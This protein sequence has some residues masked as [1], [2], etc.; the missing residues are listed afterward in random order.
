M[1]ILEQMRT[2]ESMP[3]FDPSKWHMC[4]DHSWENCLQTSNCYAYAL[5]RPDYHWAIPGHGFAKARPR[6][7]FESYDTFFRDL[8]HADHRECLVQGACQD[9]LT[10]VSRPQQKAGYYSVAL[11]FSHRDDYGFHW[12]R[13]DGDGT[14]SHKDGWRTVSNRDTEGRVILDP[15]QDSQSAYSI[16][17]GFFLAPLDGIQLQHSFPPLK[18]GHQSVDLIPAEELV[19]SRAS[20]EKPL[21]G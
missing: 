9:G 10:P 5:N 7:V 12:Y 16:L 20:A 6:H 1:G 11:F 19:E 14:W 2:E 15:R 18:A 21:A 17:G 4:Q 13:Q 8:T 3:I